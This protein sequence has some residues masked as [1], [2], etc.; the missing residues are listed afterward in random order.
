MPFQAVAWAWKIPLPTPVHKLTLIWLA[1]EADEFG[2]LSPADLGACAKFSGVS[3]RETCAT[4][5]GLDDLGL[6]AADEN[7]QVL[8][9]FPLTGEAG[10]DGGCVANRVPIEPDVRARVVS[11]RKC[12]ACPAE[13]DVEADH[14][15][16]RKIGGS[17]EECN[18]QPLCSD[19]NRRKHAKTGWV[20]L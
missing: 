19:C 7:F 13:G 10:P 4:I 3:F 8:V 2:L 1:K 18:L 17:N 11:A 9:G 20:S 6:L 5:R 16:P 12:F 14:I 15:F